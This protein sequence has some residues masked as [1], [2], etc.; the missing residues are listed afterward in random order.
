MTRGWTTKGDSEIAEW[1][2]MEADFRLEDV[3]H[4]PAYFDLK[5]LA[6]FNG[7]YI[8][9]LSPEAFLE[10]CRPWLTATDAPY[11][12]DNFRDDVFLAMPEHIQP[13]CLTLADA[14]G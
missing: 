14:P 6:A 5:K 3:N 9:A 13:R 4:S 11:P 1:A 7:E 12:V 2:Q 8:R 10:A